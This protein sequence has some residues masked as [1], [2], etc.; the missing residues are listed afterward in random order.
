MSAALEREETYRKIAAEE[1]VKHL[2]AMKE[3]DEAKNVLSE[4]AYER[5]VAVL[6]AHKESLEKK[7]IVNELFCSDRRY[8]KYTRDEIEVATDFFS[9]SN[10]IGQGGYGK[11]YKCCLHGTPV[12]VKVL[13]PDAVERKEEFLRE[14]IFL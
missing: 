14:V 8:R 2:Q 11:V 7:K 4:E 6:N 5:Q 10:V 3:V 12:A 9:E 1:K 13:R